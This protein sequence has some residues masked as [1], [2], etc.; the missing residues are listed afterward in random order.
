MTI[1]S[2][3]HRFIFV[4]IPKTAG[5]SIA[6][7]LAPFGDFESFPAHLTALELIE[8]LGTTFF[9]YFT[10]SFVRHPLTRQASLY[11]YILREAGHPEHSVDSDFSD[12]A[13]YFAWRA[14]QV[15]LGNV[16]GPHSNRNLKQVDYLF[17]GPEL[18]VNFVGRYEH[19]KEDFQTVCDLIGVTATLPWLNSS[20]RTVS[21]SEETKGLARTTF[22]ADLKALHYEI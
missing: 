20:D 16:L 1:V 5:T 9:E 3:S 4:A 14:A 12:F 15:A 17:S 7:A 10:F 2:N 18:L 6:R 21:F 8:R 13:E 11:H 19:L 22:A